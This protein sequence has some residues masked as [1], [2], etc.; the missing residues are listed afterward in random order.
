MGQ[1][2]LVY[3]AS[4]VNRLLTSCGTAG[5]LRQGNPV[6]QSLGC[7]SSENML[8]WH[9]WA[10][11]REEAESSQGPLVSRSGNLGGRGNHM[12]SPRST[13]GACHPVPGPTACPSRRCADWTFQRWSPVGFVCL[14]KICS[15]QHSF[16]WPVPSGCLPNCTAEAGVLQ[17][18]SSVLEP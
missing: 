1:G 14:D 8:I 6:D 10:H 16:P 11:L 17:R 4:K 9:L 12:A 3:P 5:S 15:E 2:R 7:S 18:L 13:L